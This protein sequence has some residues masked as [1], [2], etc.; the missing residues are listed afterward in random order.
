[1][2]TNWFNYSRKNIFMKKYVYNLARIGGFIGL[3]LF[4]IFYSQSGVKASGLVDLNPVDGVVSIPEYENSSMFICGSGTDSNNQFSLDN[5]SSSEL[6]SLSSDANGN[7]YRIFYHYVLN[8]S[9]GNLVFTGGNSYTKCFFIDNL[10]SENPYDINIF[11]FMDGYVGGLTNP[12]NLIIPDSDTNY[13]LFTGWLFL[14][15]LTDLSISSSSAVWTG[16]QSNFGITPQV[17]SVVSNG[18]ENQSLTV[19]WNSG[20]WS[21]L[22][23]AQIIF[24]ESTPQPDPTTNI[25]GYFYFQPEYNCST[26]STCKIKYNYNQDYIPTDTNEIKIY[27]EDNNLVATSTIESFTAIGKN[28][29]SSYITFETGATTG[30]LTYYMKADAENWTFSAPITINMYDGSI[31]IDVLE[32]YTN[33]SS[34][35]GNAHDLACSTD[36]WQNGDYLQLAGCV[37]VE[38]VLNIGYKISDIYGDIINSITAGVKNIFPFSLVFKIQEQWKLSKTAE[39]PEGLAW[40]DT[41]NE[42][43]TINLELPGDWKEGSQSIPIWGKDVFEDPSIPALANFWTNIRTLTS[44]IFY[45][46]FIWSIWELGHDIYDEIMYEKLMDKRRTRDWQL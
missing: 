6:F 40:L 5:V 30:R 26:N 11:P 34:L 23:F 24:N 18:S 37:V 27:D 38:S 22:G 25:Y 42:N 28:N 14:S 31:P 16:S 15:N 2:D 21:Q 41:R 8:P 10:D 39:L 7:Y 3:F 17:Y 46:L 45:A 19:S 1:L 32:N 4:G 13:Y 44:Y 12:D 20:N 35:M 36:T 9:V 43:G 33:A 29:G